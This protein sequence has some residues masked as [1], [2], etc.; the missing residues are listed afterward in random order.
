MTTTKEELVSVIKEWV[1]IEKEM[2][3]LQKELK[4]RRSRKKELT[5]S[6]VE[7]M[8]SNEIDC[9]DINDGK[10][11]YTKNKVREPL[12]KKLLLK[13]LDKYFENTD[14]DAARELSDYIMESRNVKIKENIRLK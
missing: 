14:P 8:K 12:S 1:S 9:F 13:C 6:L 7:T 10:I 2:K 5:I 4:E 11:L 3:V